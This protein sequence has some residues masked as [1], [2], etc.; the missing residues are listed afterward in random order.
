MTSTVRTQRTCSSCSDTT[1]DIAHDP[2][3]VPPSS[4]R[5]P[6]VL[7][8]PHTRLTSSPV[9]QPQAVRVYNPPPLLAVP[10][11]TCLLAHFCSIPHLFYTHI[12]QHLFIFARHA[13]LRHRPRPPRRGALRPRPPRPGWQ[14]CRVLARARVLGRPPGRPPGDASAPP[15]PP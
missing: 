6:L 11:L 4:A 8:S 13:R 9:A 3:D 1:V 5:R 7:D 2:L 12:L 14:A 15:P 10:L